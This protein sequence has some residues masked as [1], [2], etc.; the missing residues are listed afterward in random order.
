MRLFRPYFFMRY[1]FPEALFRIK[2]SEKILCLTFDDGPDPGSTPGLLDILN[3]FKIKA[4]FFCEGRK[5]EKYP[6]LVTR[7]VGEGHLIGNHS[8]NHLN[9]W[10]CSVNKYCKD[11]HSASQYTSGTL[12]RPPYGRIRLKQYKRLHSH[13]KIIFWDIMSYDFDDGF[14][15]ARSL[16]VLLKKIR[17]GSVIVLHDKPDSSSLK[18]LDEFLSITKTRGYKFILP[19]L[20]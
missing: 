17:S 10:L 16:K 14:V 9:G 4:I 13:F 7:I 15:A 2:S 12:F 20:N 18:I 1:L 6:L 3:G 19:Q 11:V 8:Y 5:A